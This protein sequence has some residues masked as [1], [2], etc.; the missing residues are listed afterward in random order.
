MVVTSSI[1]LWRAWDFRICRKQL[2]CIMGPK[3]I[4]STTWYQ[5]KVRLR[6]WDHLPCYCQNRGEGREDE[7]GE[8][9]G[10]VDPQI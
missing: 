1:T 10:W 2:G 7:G 6:T 9:V 8:K 5:N 4:R 3:D